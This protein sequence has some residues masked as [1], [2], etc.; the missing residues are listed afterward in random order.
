MIEE[1]LQKVKQDKVKYIL[2][3]FTDINGIVKN[4]TILRLNLQI[5]KDILRRRNTMLPKCYLML[6]I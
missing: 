6:T 2:L 3:Q 4:V 1:T 5:G